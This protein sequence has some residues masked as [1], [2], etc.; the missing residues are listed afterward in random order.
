MQSDV[1]C[2]IFDLFQFGSRGMSFNIKMDALQS[3][4]IPHTSYSYLMLE[5]SIIQY[6]ILDKESHYFETKG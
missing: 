5:I 6:N 4:C 2:D 1:L 3:S